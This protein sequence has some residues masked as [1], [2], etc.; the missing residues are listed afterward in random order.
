MSKELESSI[1]QM[2]EPKKLLGSGAYGARVEGGGSRNPEGAGP[3]K[4]YFECI[5]TTTSMP[6]EPTEK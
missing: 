2:Y 4:K 3:E 6:K 1:L 5:P